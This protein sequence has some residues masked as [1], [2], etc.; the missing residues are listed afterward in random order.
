[1]G[2]DED[3]GVSAETLRRRFLADTRGHMPRISFKPD[4]NTSDDA[5]E[6]ITP[7]AAL[8]HL[9]V[10]LDDL[11]GQPAVALYNRAPDIINRPP[12]WLGDFRP[13]P[14]EA[15]AILE[16]YLSGAATTTAADDSTQ[17]EPEPDQQKP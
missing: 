3:E 17:T 6:A 9:N 12:D 13:D 8:A 16:R 14:N 15:R 11:E 7:I 5:E 4:R 2:R 1:M 10:P